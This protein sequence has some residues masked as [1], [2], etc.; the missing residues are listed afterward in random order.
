MMSFLSRTF[1]CAIFA[2]GLQAQQNEVVL[3]ATSSAKLI[4]GASTPKLAGLEAGTVA[5]EFTAVLN[6]DLDESAV[7]A[8][9]LE[10]LPAEGA[11][12]K[13]WKE[14]GAQWLLTT[15]ISKTAKG[16]L[17]L[18]AAAIDTAAEKTVFTRTYNANRIVTLRHLAHYLADD[19]VGRLTGEKGVASSRI[20]FVRQVSPGVKEVFQVD[21]DG[22]GLLQ[23]T[24]HGSLTLSPTVAG[25]GRLAYITY[26]GGLP[27]IWGQRRKDGPDERIYPTTSGGGSGMVS[28]PVWSPDGKRMAFVEGDRR[29]NTDILVL[30]LASGRARRLTDG[31]GINTEPSWNP[32][33]T[34]LAFTSDREGGPQVY[35]MQDDGSNLRRLT[36]E[37]LYN[38]SPAW[39]PNGAMV[40]YVSRFEGKF[41]LFIFKLGEGKAYQITT[42]VSTSESP[43]WAPDERRLVFTSNRFGSSQLFTTDLSGRQI[44]RMTDLSACQSPRWI[45]GR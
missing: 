10:R 14:A 42:G 33:G 31:N 29:G 45:R 32:N 27:E 8:V 12:V 41:D 20:V 18:E 3:T 11:A 26:K 38:A 35:L 43:S 19:L 1:L 36:G 5:T 7:M 15:R 44:L 30:D 28:S 16:D 24:R 39:S 4:I 23:L 2:L 37:G 34:Q 25:D 13:A 17:Q 6:R 21:R 40:A 22:A 9:L